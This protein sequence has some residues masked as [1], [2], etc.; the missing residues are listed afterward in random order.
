MQKGPRAKAQSKGGVDMAAADKAPYPKD[1]SVRQAKGGERRSDTRKLES[2][3]TGDS[4]EALRRAQRDPGRFTGWE[5]RK[6][7]MQEKA[8]EWEALQN[9]RENCGLETPVLL[10]ARLHPGECGCPINL[11][12]SCSAVLRWPAPNGSHLAGHRPW[13]HPS[14]EPKGLPQK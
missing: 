14:P 2:K 10:F 6:Q 4:P 7:G 1:T 9:A 5:R 12:I 8:Q 13:P 11:G 3:E